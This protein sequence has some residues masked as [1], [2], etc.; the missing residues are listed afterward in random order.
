MITTLVMLSFC[1]A[2]TNKPDQQQSFKLLCDHWLERVVVDP[3][4]THSMLN[5]GWIRWYSDGTYFRRNT[6]KLRELN[7]LDFVDIARQWPGYPNIIEINLM[8]S[9]PNGV[10]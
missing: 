4:K 5:R 3:S 8:L 10:I 7:Y 6:V 2:A 1:L 9:E